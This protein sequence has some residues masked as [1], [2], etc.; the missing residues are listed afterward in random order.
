MAISLL[1]GVTAG[2]SRKHIDGAK[3]DSWKELI[4]STSPTPKPMSTPSLRVGVP[5]T[6]VAMLSPLVQPQQP[7]THAPR[8]LLP[9]SPGSAKPVECGTGWALGLRRL[10]RRESEEKVAAEAALEDVMPLRPGPDKLIKLDV[11]TGHDAAPVEAT[12]ESKHVQEIYTVIDQVFKH[13]QE[14]VIAQETPKRPG[15]REL[16]G[17]NAA[18][19]IALG[20]VAFALAF[21]PLGVGLLAVGGLCAVGW[22]VTT[23]SRSVAQQ[24]ESRQMRWNEHL[25]QNNTMQARRLAEQDVHPDPLEALENSLLRSAQSPLR[26]PNKRLAAGILTEHLARTGLRRTAAESYLRTSGMP[27]EQLS[28]VAELLIPSITP[29]GVQLDESSVN[30]A[31]NAIFNHLAGDG[32]RRKPTVPTVKVEPGVTFHYDAT[33]ERAPYG[34]SESSGGE[35][36]TE[37]DERGVIFHFDGDIKKRMPYSIASGSD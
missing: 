24:N 15:W 34:I 6:H 4:Y 21:P 29:R 35:A 10:F 16:F 27:E 30:D 23:R 17:F 8:G 19:G 14:T 9:W 32:A 2:S 26:G 11:L 22:T 31:Y 37:K 3:D 33:K 28:A 1:N 5:E 25:E 7:A 12:A 36:P 20:I 13:N 18:I